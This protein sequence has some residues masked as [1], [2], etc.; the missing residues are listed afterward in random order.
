MPPAPALPLLILFLAAGAAAAA[1]VDA[2]L[3][4]KSALTVP[5]AAAPFFAT[6]DAAAADPCGFAGV[7]CGGAG[8]RVTGLSLPGLN[9]SAASVPFADL[10]AALPS[11]AALSLPENSL[12]GGIVGVIAC[13]ALQE[14]TLAFNGF[15]S[16]IPDLSPLTKLRNLNVSSMSEFTLFPLPA[17]PQPRAQDTQKGKQHNRSR[18]T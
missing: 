13:A 3:A 15:D 12:A 11:L 18:R 2:L 10:C 5:P 6:W 7:T 8:R 9:V 16:A 1:E 17:S 14:L 4:F